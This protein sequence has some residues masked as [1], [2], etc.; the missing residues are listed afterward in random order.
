MKIEPFGERVAVKVVHPEETT[1]GGLIIAT[2][3]DTS[4]RG[5]IVAIGEGYKDYFEIGDK[6]IFLLNSGVDYTD[7]TEEYKILNNKD[8]LCK[9]IED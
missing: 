3:K 1:S 5:E 4:N 2:T 9:V 6:V 7:G 8:I